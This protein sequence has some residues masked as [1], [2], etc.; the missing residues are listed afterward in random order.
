M[1]GESGPP[2]PPARRAAT[3]ISVIGTSCRDRAL[4][5]QR[6]YAVTAHPSP[7][8]ER[9]LLAV[10]GHPQHCWAA[11]ALAPHPQ[12]PHGPHGAAN[13][14]PTP[15]S[16][17]PPG[18]QSSTGA[19]LGLPLWRQVPAHVRRVSALALA[20]G[21]AWCPGAGWGGGGG[22]WHH[23]PARVARQALFHRRPGPRLITAM[24]GGARSLVLRGRRRPL[25][26]LAQL[27]GEPVIRQIHRTPPPPL[28][29]N[30]PSSSAS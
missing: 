3:T 1:P 25:P 2:P 23:W 18:R 15:P 29:Q 8:C 27:S 19:P 28:Q 24:S 13:H 9:P 30:R 26:K 11:P 14:S 5:D 6:L 21:P 4:G 12:P 16:P 10:I 17:L 22:G 20:H 7:S